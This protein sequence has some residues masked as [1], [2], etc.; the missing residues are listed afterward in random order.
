LVQFQATLY[1]KDDVA[2]L[3]QSIN[4]ASSTPLPEL[5][6]NT[7]YEKWWPELQER[8]GRIEATAA[9]LG[10]RSPAS[11]TRVTQD[12]RDAML[13]EMLELMRVQHRLLRSPEEL[14]PP[15]Y[16]SA[17][18]GEQM[19]RDDLAAVRPAARRRERGPAIVRGPVVR[20]EEE[21]ARDFLRLLMDSADEETLGPPSRYPALFAAGALDED[22][23][24]WFLWTD[25]AVLPCVHA[26]RMGKRLAGVLSPDDIAGVGMVHVSLEL[27][28]VRWR[29]RSS[30]E[31]AL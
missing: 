31:I 20:L 22:L 24:H 18:L 6:V 7:T 2:K 30:G 9:K 8:L 4:A 17:L 13:E 19:A 11:V 28:R 16:L 5:V 29:G 27:D 23:H 12:Q 3:V 21:R 10:G 1:Q 15:G 14:L 25:Q 26:R